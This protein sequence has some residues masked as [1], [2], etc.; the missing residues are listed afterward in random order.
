VNKKLL[1]ISRAFPPS[2]EVGGQRIARFCKYLRESG[3]TPV[4]LTASN[5]DFPGTDESFPLDPGIEVHRIPANKNPLHRLAQWKRK[6]TRTSPKPNASAPPTSSASGRNGVGSLRSVLYKWVYPAFMS[7]DE[8]IWW[9]SPAVLAGRKLLKE[10]S[11]GAV[12]SSAPPWTSHLV[13]RTL[14]TIAELPWIA[15]FRDPW[16]AAIAT[17]HDYKAQFWKERERGMERRCITSAKCIICNTEPIRQA[18]LSQYRAQDPK[19]FITI[20]NGYDHLPLSAATDTSRQ[21]KQIV[22]L[23]SIY[24]GRD[25]LSFFDAVEKIVNGEFGEVP[26]FRV[27]LIGATRPGF[28]DAIT[29]RYP[30]LVRG[31]ILELQR[32]VPWVEAQ[33]IMAAADILLILQGVYSLQVPAK[34]YD[35]LATGKP[36]LA[37]GKPGALSELVS[38]TSSGV[39]ADPDDVNAVAQSLI[40]LLRSAPAEHRNGPPPAA[41]YHFQSLTKQLEGALLTAI[42]SQPERRD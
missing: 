30:E 27:R 14:S 37:V 39:S 9:Y 15:D 4:V 22:H 16:T 3:W 2:T 20:T 35:Y 23:G 18:L 12:F 21:L 41:E 42:G 24:E 17:A 8:S 29:G 36:I 19:R 32:A 6:L 5:A 26:A 38:A 10:Q 11:F 40:Q 7:P 1:V 34:F 13:A 31:Q 28:S 25:N 33:Q